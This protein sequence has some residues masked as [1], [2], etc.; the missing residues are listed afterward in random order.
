VHG[1][2]CQKPGAPLRVLVVR[3]AAI[4][5]GVV[6]RQQRQQRGNRRFSDSAGGHHQ[7]QRARRCKRCDQR[8]ERLSGSGAKLFDARARFCFRIKP[9]HAMSAPHQP[10][11][12]IRAHAPQADHPDV[13]FELLVACNS[14]FGRERRVRPRRVR[15]ASR[16]E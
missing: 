6:S 1:V 10:L 3:I 14:R 15:E 2:V 9:D 11:A 16:V 8:I 12:H 4:D 13:H 7:P 5:D